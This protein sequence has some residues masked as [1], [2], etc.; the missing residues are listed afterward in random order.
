MKKSLYIL[1][2]FLTLGAT[3]LRAQHS[4]G[5]TGLMLS[6]SADMQ[7]DGTFMV[8]AHYLPFEV[9]PSAW[10]YNTAGYSFSIT[11]LPF[12]EVGYYCTLIDLKNGTWNQDRSISFRLRAIEE[13]AWW[14]SV[15]VGSSDLLSTFE[16]DPTSDVSSNRYYGGIYGV[17]TKHFAIGAEDVALTVGYNIKTQTNSVRDGLFCGISYTPSIYD[18]GRIIAEFN[19]DIFSIGASARLFGHLS[20]YA[21][22]YDFKALVGGVRY[23]ISLF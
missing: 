19:D 2:L 8:G 21:F 5:V 12:V 16:L 1:I 10:S 7:P 4:R 9:T 18:Q 22:C 13:A 17:A 23:E 20:L 3:S 15:V 11:F 14:P 6:P